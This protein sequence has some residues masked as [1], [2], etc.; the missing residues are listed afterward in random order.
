MASFCRTCPK[1]KDEIFSVISANFPFRTRPEEELIW[2]YQQVFVITGY[3][4]SI[5]GQVLHFVIDKCLELDVEIKIHD[6]GQVTLDDDPDKD[7]G[8]FDLEM[9]TPSVS[10]P[11]KGDITV[12]EMAEKVNYSFL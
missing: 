7:D 3:V 1:A 11:Q 5:Q 4:P 6:G 10:K 2:C 9:D 12:D 8:V